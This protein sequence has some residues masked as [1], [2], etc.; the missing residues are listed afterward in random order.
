[1]E[2]G[3]GVSGGCP[4]LTPKQAVT[5]ASLRAAHPHWQWT[6]RRAGIGWNYI[7]AREPGV[8]VE[9]YAVSRLVSEDD[10]VTEWRVFSGSCSDTYAMWSLREELN[11]PPG[12]DGG[13]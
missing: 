10:F 8:E 1:M 12:R 3:E 13:V 2:M 9:V 7:G 5:L 11:R 6:S 4:R